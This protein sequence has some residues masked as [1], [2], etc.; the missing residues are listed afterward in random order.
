MVLSA[1]YQQS[2]LADSAKL[3]SDPANSLLSRM[4]RRRLTAE[5]LRD[6]MLLFSGELDPEGGPSL[7]ISDPKNHRRTVYAHI[8]RLELDSFLMQFDYPDANVH[9]AKRAQ[10]TTPTQKLF[11]LNSPFVLERCEKIANGLAG[12]GANEGIDQ[13]Y[14]KLISR[15]PAAKERQ[16]AQAFLNDGNEIDGERWAQLAQVLLCSNAFQYRD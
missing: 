5:M 3:E 10:T 4:N 9:A 11:L 1:T 15:P 6:S 8:S 16:L 2:S 14:K 13:L 12:T 7:K